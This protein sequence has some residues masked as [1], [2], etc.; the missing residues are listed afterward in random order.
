MMKRHCLAPG[1]TG[2]WE[3]KTEEMSSGVS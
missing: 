1:T 2:D 3:G